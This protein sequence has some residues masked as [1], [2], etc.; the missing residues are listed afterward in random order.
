M[1]DSD[2]L[3]CKIAE[4]KIPAKIVYEDDRTLAFL[5][6]KPSAPGHT[7]VIPKYHA[8]TLA[9]LPDK[10]IAPLFLAVKK[11]AELL[12][13]GLHPDGITIGVNQGRASGQ[14]IDHLHVHLVPRSHGDGG[15]SVQSVVHQASRESLEEIQKKILIQ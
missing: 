1:Q 9:A 4:K 15:G 11:V 14:E 8:S 3:F 7:M 5:D 2:C 6:I 13:A 10:E 12:V